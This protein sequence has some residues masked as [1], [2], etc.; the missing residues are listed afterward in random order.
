MAKDI[1]ADLPSIKDF[2]HHGAPAFREVPLF[3]HTSVVHTSSTEVLANTG[4]HIQTQ[5][6]KQVRRLQ[7]LI[8]HLKRLLITS[9]PTHHTLCIQQLKAVQKHIL[10][11]HSLPSNI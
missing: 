3:P 8:N 4:Y 1:G 10:S 6:L 5:L 9:C 7:G 11:T 2:T